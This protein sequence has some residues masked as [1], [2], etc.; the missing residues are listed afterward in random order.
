VQQRLAEAIAEQQVAAEP[1]N[2]LRTIGEQLA[3]TRG[4]L[5]QLRA[6]DAAEL[7]KWLEA[8][9]PGERPPPSVATLSAERRL[10]GL[11]RD[12]PG[13]E[14]ALPAAL[15]REQSASELV[16][17][18]H[19]ERLAAIE[20]VVPETT[21]A[22]FAEYRLQMRKLLTVEAKLRGL[23]DVLRQQQMMGA[24]EK[25]TAE[26]AA[27]RRE[28]EVPRDDQPALQLLTRL[29]AADPEAEL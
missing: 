10:A 19:V 7:G 6:V 14:A 12:Q 8:G 21:A 17:R 4:E 13:V 24:W 22:A 3:V 18:L 27:V 23:V 2:R 11:L 5:A 29:S 15:Q 28:I 1:A 16:A 25:V 20:N 26:L 9:M